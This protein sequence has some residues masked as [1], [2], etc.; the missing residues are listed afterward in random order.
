MLNAYYYDTPALF[1]QAIISFFQNIN[2]TSSLKLQKL[3]TLNFQFF[4]KNIAY[5]YAA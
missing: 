3:L 5:S 4:D 2:Q 1:H